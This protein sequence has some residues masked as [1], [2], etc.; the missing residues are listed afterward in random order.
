MKNCL[1][2]AAVALAAGAAGYVIYQQT[3]A[4]EAAAPAA[5]V[6]AEAEA[7]KPRPMVTELPD[8]SL[9]NREG[10]VQSLRSWTGK[11][12]IVN[13]WAT[14]CAPCRKEIP[15]LKQIA[16]QTASEGFQVVGVAIDFKDDVLKYANEV[17]IDYPLLIGE[18]EGMAAADAF[19]VESVG[20][21]FTAFSDSKGR[22]VTTFM[23]EL[24]KETID[25][26]LAAVKK[27][28]AGDL[29]PDAAR[30]QIASDLQKI[31]PHAG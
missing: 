15:L 21:P 27:V 10:Q 19:G 14:W 28:N 31:A 30:A 24:T 7:P 6:V 17:K 22:M 13:F 18:T 29:T 12:M 8:V 5:E 23:G 3:R 16:A 11:S 26:I 1:I 25:V 2:I 20:L 4:P 9:P